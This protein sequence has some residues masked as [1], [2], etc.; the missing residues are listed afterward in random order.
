[1][2]GHFSQSRTREDYLGLL[3]EETERNIAYDQNQLIDSTSHQA[4][5]FYYL[6]NVLNSCTLILFY[7]DM[8]QDGGI[9]R[10]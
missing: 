1:M 2:C 6:S 8:L 9:S 10:P 5:N 3:A 7:G 4:H